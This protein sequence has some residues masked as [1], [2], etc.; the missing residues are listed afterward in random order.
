MKRLK[1]L[2]WALLMLLLAG[3]TTGA[4]AVPRATVNAA[5]ERSVAITQ[6]NRPSVARLVTV[7]VGRPAANFYQSFHAEDQLAYF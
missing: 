7:P 4:A 1:Y 3:V 5:S 6:E 2:V